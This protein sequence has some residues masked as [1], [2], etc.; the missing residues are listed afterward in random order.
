M[1]AELLGIDSLEADAEMVA[2]AADCL[3]ACLLYTSRL[4]IQEG[5]FH[6]VKRMFH[7]VGKEVI[8]LKRLSMGTLLLDETL[9]SGEYRALTNEELKRLC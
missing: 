1:G 9:K 2:L 3:K 7:A 5:K 8:Y 4:T 6:Q